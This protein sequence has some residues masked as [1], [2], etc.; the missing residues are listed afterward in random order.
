MANSRNRRKGLGEQVGE[1]ITP[2]SQKSN[3][4]VASEKLTGLGDKAASALQPGK[5]TKTL[6]QRVSVQHTNVPSPADSEKSTTQK[7]GDST[8]GNADSAQKDGA[9]Y[10]D[11]AKDTLASAANVASE[12]LINAGK[13]DFFISSGNMN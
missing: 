5:S 12:T 10:V 9:S 2:Q 7:L 11:Q 13:L 4:D 8:R 6:L 1:K 3:T